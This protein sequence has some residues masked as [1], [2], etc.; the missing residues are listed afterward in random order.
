MARLNAF[1]INESQCPSCGVFRPKSDVKRLRC[2]VCKHT[3][4][5]VHDH[6]SDP[7]LSC[8]RQKKWEDT[9]RLRIGRDA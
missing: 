1:Q 6:P 3:K 5:V 4:M 8:Q 7:L 2:S 9:G